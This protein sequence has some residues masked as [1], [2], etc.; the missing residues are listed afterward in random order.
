MELVARET[1][2]LGVHYINDV[3]GSDGK[4]RDFF[5]KGVQ[6]H[7]VLAA[8]KRLLDAGRRA[9]SLV[10]LSRVSFREN[11]PDLIQ[12]GPLLSMVPQAGALLRGTPG[13][14]IA[15]ELESQPEDLIV[16]HVRLGGFHG[17]DLDV[18]LR[19]H[20]ITTVLIAGVATNI[21]VE[22]AARQA[23][24]LG[25]RTVVVSDASSAATDEAHDA[26]LETLRLIG[27]VSTVDEV[28]AALGRG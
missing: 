12:N 14:E 27:E 21:S 10:I 15:A 2:V 24:D 6:E 22:G 19:S 11:Y 5:H 8:A 16:D 4:F 17:S 26:S 25:Y 1:A 20:G 23:L 3:V 9:G 18:L 7:G 13:V 28:V